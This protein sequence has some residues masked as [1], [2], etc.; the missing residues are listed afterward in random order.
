[1]SPKNI[2]MGQQCSAELFARARELRRQM[3]PAERL[4]WQEL[5]ANRFEGWHFRRQQVIA[6]YIVDF[7]C[8]K[9]GLAVELDGAVHETQGGYD[10]E[11]DQKLAEY[12]VHV[13]RFQNREVFENVQK[14]KVVIFK[15]CE[16]TGRTEV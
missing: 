4:L 13:L 8:H 2:V 7:Y 15:A 11:R 1:M 9:V 6:G 5:R 16:E 10:T 3:T 12:G 14:V